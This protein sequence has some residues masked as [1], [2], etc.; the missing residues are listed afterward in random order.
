MIEEV[1]HTSPERTLSFLPEGLV[2][3]FRH[4]R[5]TVKRIKQPSK[6]AVYSFFSL[7]FLPV[8][9]PVHHRCQLQTESCGLDQTDVPCPQSSQ[10][11]QRG[12]FNYSILSI[13]AVDH[14]M[15]EDENYKHKLLHS[16][17]PRM[18]SSKKEQ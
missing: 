13:I 6:T 1:L 5:L 10:L 2:V 12:T 17:A 14:V 4:L 16:N 8:S 11:L 7:G 15:H 18:D 9:H 3:T